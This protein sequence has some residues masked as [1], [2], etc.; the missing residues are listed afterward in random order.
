[1]ESGVKCCTALGGQF[2][3]PSTLRPFIE[4][5][6][7]S[8]MGGPSMALALGPSAAVPFSCDLPFLDAVGWASDPRGPS[9][10]PMLPGHSSWSRVSTWPKLGESASF[11][12]ILP[13]GVWREIASFLGGSAGRVGMG[14]ISWKILRSCKQKPWWDR[15]LPGSGLLF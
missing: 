9:T 6:S 4:Q 15:A 11:L 3:Q 7:H 2:C 13:T 14:A 5:L 12:G 8:F 1:M 10:A